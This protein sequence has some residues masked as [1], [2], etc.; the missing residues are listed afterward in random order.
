M[1]A[2]TC[3]KCSRRF[4]PVAEVIQA[5]LAASQG[6][7]H[8]QL[9]CPHCGK[10][11]KVAPERLKPAVRLNPPAPAAPPAPAEPAEPASPETPA[12]PMGA[13]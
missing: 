11:N 7:K 4:T 3:A 8:A 10:G 13:A 6:Q 1:I 9:I 5:A 2:I 12:E